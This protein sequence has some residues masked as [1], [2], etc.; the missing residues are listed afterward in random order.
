MAAVGADLADRPAR[1]GRTTS[2][3]PGDGTRFLAHG[4]SSLAALMKG[5]SSL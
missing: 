2:D 5:L 1:V 4:D 3:L